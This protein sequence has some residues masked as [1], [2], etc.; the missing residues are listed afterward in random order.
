[1]EPA[2]AD[3]LSV[4]LHAN[5][6]K[7]HYAQLLSIP[8]GY[9]GQYAEWLETSQKLVAKAM[10]DD[11]P[12]ATLQDSFLQAIHL[13]AAV[14]HEHNKANLETFYVSWQ[15]H[16]K[17]KQDRQQQPDGAAQQTSPSSPTPMLVLPDKH[18]VP[19]L[20][21]P[22]AASASPSSPSV[23]FSPR[24]EPS[25]ASVA[26]PSTNAMVPYSP[27]SP[28]TPPVV[29]PESSRDHLKLQPSK[30]VTLP[31][32]GPEDMAERSMQRRASVQS[33]G[34]AELEVIRNDLKTSRDPRYIQ[35]VMR[36]HKHSAVVQEQAC[37]TIFCITNSG[38]AREA[39]GQQGLLEDLQ[40]A[41]KTHSA[42]EIIQKRAIKAIT[43]TVYGHKRNQDLAGEQGLIQ[44]IQF[45]MR[46]YLSIPGI[47]ECSL[48][49]L[50]N[51]TQ[52]SADNCHRCLTLGVLDD[53][54]GA[55]EE[56]AGFP[57][58]QE[59]A[60]MAL[61]HMCQNTELRA[62]IGSQGLLENIQTAL[63]DHPQFAG[64]CDRACRAIVSITKANIL[65][66]EMA[67][68]LGLLKHIKNAMATHRTSAWIQEKSCLAITA[69]AEDHD[70]NKAAAEHLKILEDIQ[71][72]MQVLLTW[73]SVQEKALKA[74][75]TLCANFQST[76][77][78]ASTLSLILD[79]QKAM[80][81]YPG[82]STIQ[83]LASDVTV[84]LTNVLQARGDAGEHGLLATVQESMRSFPGLPS[85]QESACRAI[86][87][88]TQ[89]H[90]TNTARAG[91]L[92]LLVELQGALRRHR[93]EAG[94][95]E[96]AC[97]ALCNLTTGN[98]A[99][100]EIAGKLGILEDMQETM[101]ANKDAPG[102]QA[103][104]C[105]TLRNMI[106]ANRDNREKADESGLKSDVIKAAAIHPSVSLVKEAS[107]SA[108]DA[109]DGEEPKKQ[110]AQKQHGPPSRSSSGG[111]QQGKA[112]S[113]NYNQGPKLP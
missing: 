1:M 78:Q 6:H 34:S 105:L 10:H 92:G 39:I 89:D 28:R 3:A 62:Q 30:T 94:V 65:H 27:E 33:C 82:S 47:Q 59:H 13:V 35:G 7:L 102:V 57:R 106:Y 79:V 25:Q 36:A 44:D 109:L 72:A 48:V 66:K 9:L 101:R 98:A 83:T 76:Q 55:M 61:S 104:A 74:I 41:M 58:I 11:I 75:F 37:S 23:C 90:S 87:N 63:A 60:S 93:E 107:L 103:Q 113:S 81:A 73:A 5:K 12:T 43:N 26:V 67:M 17:S 100:V 68:D 15:A 2:E 45:A 88:I 40:A 53:I 54:Q 50:T 95:Q 16:Q 56:H 8:K 24:S 31:D 22:S 42:A 91:R 20:S 14:G 19:Q 96:Q 110:A 32:A 99:N 21:S 52:H 18:V 77:L 64:V 112:L 111:W 108:L 49:A 71:S 46:G 38:A 69:I 97:G 51:L 70:K 29:E 4:V 80:K 86:R 85:L 84:V